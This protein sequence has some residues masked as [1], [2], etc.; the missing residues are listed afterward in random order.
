MPD[1]NKLAKTDLIKIV[2]ELKTENERLKTELEALKCKYAR[3]AA[4]LNRNEPKKNPK[5]SGRKPGIGTF[6]NRAPPKPEEITYTILEDMKTT[7]SVQEQCLQINN[8]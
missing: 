2:L 4:P 5:S 7:K 6:N 3:Q 8:S 1:P